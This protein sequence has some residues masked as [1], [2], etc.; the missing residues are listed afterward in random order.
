M[1]KLIS[2]LKEAS[3]IL[4]L[5]FDK[6]LYET[7]KDYP[8]L[9]SEHYLNLIDRKNPLS[10]PIFI[11]SFPSA[12]EIDISDSNL[13]EDPQCEESYSPLPKLVHRYKD[14]ALILV[15]NKCST[16]CRFCFRKRYWGKG[17][18]DRDLSDRELLDIVNYLSSK[19]EIEEVI[20][21]GGDPLM[22][23]D[24]RLKFILDSVC[25]LSSIKTI[26]V[27]SRMPVTFPERITLALAEMLSK[28]EELWFLTHFNHPKELSTE[29]I[30]ACRKITS[31]GIPMLNQTVLLKGVNDSPQIL[32]K[33]FRE[34]VNYRV[35][36]YYLFHVDPVR[37]VTH[38]ATGIE[39]GL[40]IMRYF[41]E[42]LSG[43]ATPQ[44]AIDLPE[45]G[46]KV[47]LQPSYSCDKKIFDSTESDRRIEYYK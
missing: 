34:L 19:N 15:T 13:T 8:F 36:P 39:K 44:F 31:A 6:K 45:G 11:Q 22:L 46:G 9:I 33:L 12:K 14:R 7:E 16:L 21:S 38:F 27:A 35:K 1:T 43:L 3:E 26:R 17:S 10:D 47:A 30:E 40:E 37:G 2:S 5:D 24:A 23:S 28:Y 25:A 18:H 41:R 20:I 4:G 32:K 42:N 29:S